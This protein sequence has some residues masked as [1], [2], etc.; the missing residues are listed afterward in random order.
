[1]RKPASQAKK[2]TATMANKAGMTIS[3]GNQWRWDSA[4]A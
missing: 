1:M 2:A 3:P 4:A